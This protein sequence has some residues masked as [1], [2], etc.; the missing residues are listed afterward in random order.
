MRNKLRVAAVG[1]SVVCLA[2]SISAPVYAT[3]LPKCPVEVTNAKV[4]PTP[5]GVSPALSAYVKKTLRNQ[6]T[7]VWPTSIYRTAPSWTVGGHSCYFYDPNVASGYGGFLP[8]GVRV[9]Y[10]TMIS[11][12]NQKLSGGYEMFLGYAKIGGGWKVLQAGSSP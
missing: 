10:E 8:K 6:I 1:L 5:K 2:V 3:K 7:K 12:K 9:G 4:V 11:L